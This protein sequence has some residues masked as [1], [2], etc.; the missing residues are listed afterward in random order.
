MRYPVTVRFE[1]VNYQGVNT[2]QYALDE[3][4]EVEKPKVKAKA[5]SKAKAKVRSGFP[6]TLRLC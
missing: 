6:C 3:L 5:K 4:I 2:N 1:K